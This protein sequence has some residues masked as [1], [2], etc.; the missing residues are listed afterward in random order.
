MEE[1]IKL[2]K[3]QEKKRCEK[4]LF[5]YVMQNTTDKISGI[6]KGVKFELFE[7]FFINND[8]EVVTVFSCKF[9]KIQL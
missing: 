1:V 3:K 9:Y 4:Q 2:V 7:T 8:S 6:Y 5:L